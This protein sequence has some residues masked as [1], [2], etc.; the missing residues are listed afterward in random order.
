MISG[1]DGSI[2]ATSTN[3]LASRVSLFIGVERSGINS[4]D[5]LLVT[6]TI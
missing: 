2:L 6:S 1:T 4:M 5:S 3:S